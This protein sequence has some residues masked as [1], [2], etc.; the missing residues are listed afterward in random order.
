METV[1]SSPDPTGSG[2]ETM[3]KGA[4]GTQARE[5]IINFLANRYRSAILPD[6]HCLLYCVHDLQA[7]IPKEMHQAWMKEH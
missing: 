3:E 4:W 6:D 2:D 1:V 7:G 5:S